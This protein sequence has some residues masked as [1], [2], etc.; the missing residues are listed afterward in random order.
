MIMRNRYVCE[1]LPSV[2]E[3]H[4]V[5]NIFDFH[6]EQMD[7]SFGTKKVKG[8]ENVHVRDEDSDDDL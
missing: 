6:L 1:L 3:F 2:N 8:S 7:A 4:S 5:T